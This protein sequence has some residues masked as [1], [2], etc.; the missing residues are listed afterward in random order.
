VAE[1]L[2]AGLAIVSLHA[3]MLPAGPTLEAG[4]AGEWIEWLAMPA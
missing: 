1:G 2:P 4:P 3:A